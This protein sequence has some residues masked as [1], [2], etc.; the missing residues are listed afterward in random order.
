M[1]IQV[2]VYSDENGLHHIAM[3]AEEEDGT[4]KRTMN[5]PLRLLRDNISGI[6]IPQGE[7]VSGHFDRQDRE[8]NSPT[9]T[10]HYGR[11]QSFYQFMREK[12]TKN[13]FVVFAKPSMSGRVSRFQLHE[14]LLK[15]S[16]SQRKIAMLRE[17]LIEAIELWSEEEHASRLIKQPAQDDLVYAKT[18]RITFERKSAG[19]VWYDGIKNRPTKNGVVVAKTAD[20]NVQPSMNEGVTQ[21]KPSAKVVSLPPFGKATVNAPA[22]PK[23]SSTHFWRR[24]IF[25]RE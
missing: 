2:P 13:H 5:E 7:L 14:L 22:A 24:F 16:T 9:V 15:P 1:L 12:L 19:V 21:S 11:P 25:N 20:M 3:Y 23:Q 18:Q 6:S 4:F 8:W 17:K 10:Y